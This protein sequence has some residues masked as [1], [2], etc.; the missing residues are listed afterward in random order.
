MNLNMLIVLFQL[1]VIGYRTTLI[2]YT[3]YRIEPSST[4]CLF[5]CT[6]QSGIY[7]IGPFVYTRADDSSGRIYNDSNNNS[8]F[9]LYI[10]YRNRQSSRSQRTS[11]Q[12]E[13]SYPPTPEVFPVF[14]FPSGLPSMPCPEVA[15]PL[16][17][18]LDPLPNAPAILLA[19]A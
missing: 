15:E 16:L 13:C 12:V 4:S 7:C 9:I 19:A 10:V 14:P 6:T 5:C 1:K 11:V 8:S 2:V 17:P 3:V 18:I